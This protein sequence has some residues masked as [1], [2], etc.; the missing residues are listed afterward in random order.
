VVGFEEYP[1]VLVQEIIL[2]EDKFQGGVE[3]ALPRGEVLAVELE[4][5]DVGM[6]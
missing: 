1:A 6:D 3:L 2:M 5:F 4:I